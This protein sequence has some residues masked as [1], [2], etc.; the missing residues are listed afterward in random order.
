MKKRLTPYPVIAFLGAV[1]AAA[2]ASIG[3]P[4]GGPYDFTPPKVVKCEPA[5]MSVNN[6]DKRITISFDEFIILENASEKVVVS[7]PQ[8]EMPEIRTAGKK[9]HITLHDTL[10][11][12]TT[13]TVDFADAIV[14][15]NEKNPMGNF[16]YSFS[17]GLNIDTMEVAGTLLESENLEPIKGMLVGLYSDL[18]DTAFT[19]LPFA[20]VSRTDSRGRFSIKGVASG[21][22]RIYAL[23][24][25]DANFCFSQK[26]EKIAFDTL[27]IEPSCAPDSRQDTT[28]IDST[29]IDTIKTIHFTHFYPDNLILRAFTEEIRDVHLL[30]TERPLP[31]M[32]T[33]Y[34]TAPC[35]TLPTL[36]GLNFDGTENMILER[37]THNDTL[38]YW[39]TDT[40][41]SN[42]DTLKFSLTYLDTDTLG[43][44]VPRTDTLDLIAKISRTRQKEERQKKIEAWEDQQ[45]K[46]KRRQKEKFVA[47]PNPHLREDFTYKAQPSGSISPLE[48]IKFTFAEPIACVDSTALHFYQYNAKDSTWHD[49]PYLFLPVENDMRSYMLYAEWHPGE[50][51]KFE[52]DSNAVQSILGKLSTAI[53]REI[54]A[55]SEE[56]FGALF[57]RLILK[58]TAAIVQL[59]DK[60]DKPVRS[61]KAV[62]NRADFFYLKPGEYYLRLF[63]DRNGDGKWSTGDYAA[64]RQAEEVFYFPKPLVVRARWEVEQDWDVR[65]I[66]LNKQK[67]EVITKQKPDA[68]NNARQRNMERERERERNRH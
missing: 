4:D 48:N 65:G 47:K 12:N 29:H 6:K 62:N 45:K 20:R 49:A 41:V 60:G 27:L 10:Q 16:T 11:K 37:S 18:S 55:A 22:Y 9:I 68:E 1:L 58:D 50:K 38:T 40:L 61:V 52:A 26:A 24:D 31:D 43:Q 54:S 5:N 25:M 30:K 57:I 15:N 39:I 3:S 13:Y 28:W 64:G 44:L 2:C 33:L 7:P 53:K 36:K 66:P 23:Q 42:L 56:D 34:F 21:K 14:D 17:T 67:P 59:M 46:M 8:K 51:Y 63:I 35:D 32:F 19:T